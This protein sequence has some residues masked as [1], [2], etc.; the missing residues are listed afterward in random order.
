MQNQF[1]FT[2]H[3]SPSSM[4]RAFPTDIIAQ[5]IQTGAILPA[6]IP[7]KSYRTFVLAILSIKT[8]GTDAFSRIW[9]AIRIIDA[10]ALFLAIVSIPTQGAKI[11]TVSSIKSRWTFA[12]SRYF[13]TGSISTL[14]YKIAGRSKPTFQASVTYSRLM[15]THVKVCGANAIL[16]T[17]IGLLVCF[18]TF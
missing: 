1:S 2:P 8:I 17:I 6:I 18:E 11:F 10:R 3:S 14:A 13:V 5:S 4:A 12:S 15:V 7:K 9:R 16:T